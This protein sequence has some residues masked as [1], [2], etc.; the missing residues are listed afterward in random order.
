MQIGLV[1]YGSL[2]TPSGGY[3]YDRRLV[4]FL[5]TQGDAVHVIS[6]P[7][8]N[9]ASHLLENLTLRLPSGPDKQAGEANHAAS[10]KRSRKFD[11]ILQD[12]LNAPSLLRANHAPRSA[13][14]V[15][16]IHHLRSSEPSNWA[17]R[18][19]HQGIEKAFLRALDAIVCNSVTTRKAVFNLAGPHEST[20][21]APPPTDRFGPPLAEDVILRRA[22]R[23]GPLRLVFLGNVIRRK[24]L[25]TLLSAL[26]LVSRRSW[27]LD[28]VGSLEMEPRYA[29]RVRHRAL[30]MHSS[31]TIRF[32]G[33]LEEP[34]VGRILRGSDALVVPSEYEGFGIAYLEGMCFG[35]PALG[36][37]AGAASEIITDGVDGFLNAPDDAVRL[38]E[39]LTRLR[40]RKEL[41]RMSLAA[42]RRYMRQPPWSATAT[43]IRSFFRHLVSAG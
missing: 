15:G 35:L 3:Y 40:E 17:S 14:I 33:S 32:H 30:S 42:R 10:E 25:H 23:P 4:E 7:E 29:S 37:T 11:L 26:S 43:R 2:E 24:G 12:E 5:R 6:L 19:I 27:S 18:A 34:Q 21:V 28:V 22:S 41:S 31:D 9:L 39:S 20:L 38:A 36:T 13:P 16:L 1:I 8:G